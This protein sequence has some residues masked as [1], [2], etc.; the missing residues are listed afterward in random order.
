M[1]AEYLVELNIPALEHIPAPAAAKSAVSA[2]AKSAPKLKALTGG[3][4]EFTVK[5]GP[6]RLPTRGEAARTAS[7]T[8]AKAKGVSAPKG[9][10]GLAAAPLPPTIVGGTSAQQAA[11]KQAHLEGFR[12]CE[13]ALAGLANDARYKE[14]FGTHTAARFSKVKSVFAKIRKR[15]TT[16]TFTYDLSGTGCK[17]GTFAYTYKG[18]TTIWFCGAFWTAPAT[19][20]DSKAGTVVHEHSHSDASTDDLTYGQAN[21]RALAASDPAQATRNADNFEYYAEG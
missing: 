7:A 12:L 13:A 14:W 16:V 15:M 2:L 5:K 4:T 6:L 20:T 21:A 11:A 10:A 1:P 3:K 8:L 17:S 19:G 9:A 18:G